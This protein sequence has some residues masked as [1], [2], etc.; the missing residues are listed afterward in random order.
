MGMYDNVDYKADCSEC[1]TPL[2][3]FQTKDT[4]CTLSTVS[5][6]ECRNFY[7]SCDSCGSWN[8]FDVVPTEIVI[9]RTTENGKDRRERFKRIRAAY[10]KA[11]K[12]AKDGR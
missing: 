12:E 9:E 3:D 2:S 6:Y 1:G 4:D 7:T 10:D 8:E 11:M 5:V